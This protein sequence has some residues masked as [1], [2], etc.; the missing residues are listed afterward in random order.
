LP[1]IGVFV[2]YLYSVP[3]LATWVPDFRNL[4]LAMILAFWLEILVKL[5]WHAFD[6]RKRY[7]RAHG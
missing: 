3:R 4:V 7:A 1:A 2:L 5:A 6:K